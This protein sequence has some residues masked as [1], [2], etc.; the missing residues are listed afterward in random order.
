MFCLAPTDLV[1]PKGSVILVF[2]HVP[3][4]SSVLKYDLRKFLEVMF[5]CQCEMPCACVAEL[6]PGSSSMKMMPASPYRVRFET[7]TEGQNVYG[8]L[9]SSPPTN[10]AL[11]IARSGRSVSRDVLTF[12]C[13]SDGL[14]VS[15]GHCQYT[16]SS[17]CNRKFL[18]KSV[19]SPI[20]SLF[21]ISDVTDP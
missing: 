4:R 9:I 16:D 11:T 5:F 1:L 3:I 6:A 20:F 14:L 10:F 8:L 12:G 2:V 13:V 17:R 19:N 18:G 21:T 7:N 15:P